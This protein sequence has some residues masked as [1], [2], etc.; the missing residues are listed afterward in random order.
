MNKHF[1]R[2]GIGY[3]IGIAM[4]VPGVSGGTIAVILRVYDEL[5]N[6][7][8]N[9]LRDFNRNIVILFEYGAGGLLG[10]V[11]M[12]GVVSFLLYSAI[13]PTMYFFIGTIL[14]GLF[15]ISRGKSIKIRALPV[16]IGIVIVT[17]LQFVPEGIL[18]Y[19]GENIILRMSALII[20]GILLAAALILPGV[21]FSLMLVII[22]IY[23]RFLSAV[24][25]F[26]VLYLLPIVL[27]TLAGVFALAGVMS[28][29]MN[30]FPSICNSLIF[31]FVLASV[32]QLYPGFPAGWGLII[33]TIMLAGGFVCSWG[34]SV[35]FSKVR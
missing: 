8:S 4:L 11:S 26:D 27:C 9:L 35:I 34:I 22:G 5:L 1:C 18:N 23:P 31:G 15:L 30:R 2:V 10:F 33:C 6:S 21:S 7:V 16:L 14:G 12:A 29:F 24:K 3:L 25:E 32:G 19:A 13:Q 20:T 28:N 17:L